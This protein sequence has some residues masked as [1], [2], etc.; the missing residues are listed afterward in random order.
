MVPADPILIQGGMGVAVSTWRLAGAVARAGQLGV[1]SGTALGLVVARRLQQGDPGG[2]MRRALEHFPLTA[3]AERI[4]KQYYIAGGKDDGDPFGS[5]GGAPAY[6]L[7]PELAELTVAANFTEVWLAKEG[8]G[9][10][11]GINYL[12]KLQL[13]ALPSLFGAMLAGVDYVLMGA[14]IPRTIPA[15]MDQLAAGQAAEVPL[16]IEG[17]A[18]ERIVCTFDPDKFC[19]GKAPKLARPRFLAIVSSATLADALVRKSAGVIHGFVIERASAGGHNAPPRGA[20]QL[21]ARGEPIYGD[22]D[23]PDL[24][25]FRELGL[26]F[27]LAG[28]RADPAALGEALG[29]GA[30]GVQVG[31]AFAFCEESG[32]HAELKRRVLEQCRAGDLEVFTDPLASPTGFPFKVL[33]L[34]GTLSDT[35]VYDERPRTCDVGYLRHPYRKPDGTVGYRCPA[36]PLEQYA[37]KQGAAGDTSG[38]K[39]LCNALMATAGLAQVDGEGNLEPVILTAGED[40]ARLARFLRPGCDSYTA[41]DVIAYVLAGAK[42]AGD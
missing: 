20:M 9:G 13:T 40:A 29:A 39:C 25:R 21:S 22:R 19:A 41:A 38:R 24:E 32:V 14:G 10:V 18:G 34:A 17:P 31:T 28:R 8:H 42:P 1:V 36:E 16:D 15:A 27:W 3:I 30:A 26:P 23:L 37:G 11:V 2:H 7:R 12:E 33:R 5:C 4:I 6:P 35:A